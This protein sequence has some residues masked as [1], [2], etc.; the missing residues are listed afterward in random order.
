MNTLGAIAALT[1]IATWCYFLLLACWAYHDEKWGQA[2]AA[3]CIAVAFA[4][5]KLVDVSEDS[6]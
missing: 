3:A 6:D 1:R 5:G 4:C 2:V